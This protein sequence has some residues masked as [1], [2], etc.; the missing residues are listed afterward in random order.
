M[1]QDPPRLE[2]TEVELT[3]QGVVSREASGEFKFKIPFVDWEAGV[4]GGLTSE[5]T[6]TIELTFVPAPPLAVAAK[7]AELHQEL[8]DGITWV[9]RQLKAASGGDV[10]LAIKSAAVGLEFVIDRKGDFALLVFKAGVATKWSNTIKLTLS[11]AAS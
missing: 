2:V 11:P 9:R 8:V 4:G 1:Q 5:A 3:L 6:H 10:P 7:A